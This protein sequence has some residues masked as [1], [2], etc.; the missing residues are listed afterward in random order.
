MLCAAG[1]K[2]RK[3]IEKR[4]CGNRWRIPFLFSLRFNRQRLSGIQ[5]QKRLSE[6]ILIV[7]KAAVWRIGGVRINILRF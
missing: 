3:R 6:N 4:E 5:F 7:I 2:F 1:G